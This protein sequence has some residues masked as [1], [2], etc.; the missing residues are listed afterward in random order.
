MP[1]PMLTVD[2]SHNLPSVCRDLKFHEVGFSLDD[3]PPSFCCRAEIERERNS[4]A[5][6][7]FDI[8]AEI[9]AMP[10][11]KGALITAAA[12]LIEDIC[13]AKTMKDVGR[14]KAD[15]NG[16]IRRSPFEA[17]DDNRLRQNPT[18]ATKVQFQAAVSVAQ[19]CTSRG[20]EACPLTTNRNSSP[21]AW[22]R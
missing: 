16:S 15:E 19:R 20:A 11:I 14:C 2:L 18:P 6:R 5:V 12:V 13:E 1:E 10:L 7:F 4:R 9:K 21:H 22:R 8:A 17:V 3:S